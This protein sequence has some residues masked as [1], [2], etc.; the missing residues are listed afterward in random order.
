MACGC[1][2]FSSDLVEDN[3]Y[4][5]SSALYRLMKIWFY[6]RKL[7]VFVRNAVYN[8]KYIIRLLLSRK[9]WSLVKVGYKI[10]KRWKKNLVTLK[11]QNF[12]M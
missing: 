7:F 9:F 11:L 5:R 10:L 6:C 3:V 1:E 2:D 4:Y 8:E 12:Q